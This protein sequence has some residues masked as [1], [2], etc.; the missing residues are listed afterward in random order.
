MW[1]ALNWLFRRRFSRR[2]F[3]GNWIQTAEC[4]PKSFVTAIA[5]SRHIHFEISVISIWMHSTESYHQAKHWTCCN[6]RLRIGCKK[7]CSFL[8]DTTQ[9]NGA[10]A[11]IEKIKQW[12]KSRGPFE[13]EHRFTEQCYLR[14]QRYRWTGHN[15]YVT[16]AFNEMVRLKKCTLIC[17][18]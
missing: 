18:V 4:A 9:S 14:I 1:F 6:N 12:W 16:C 2:S 17:I 7:A 10:D 11:S 5:T 3:R 8:L 13:R 15:Y